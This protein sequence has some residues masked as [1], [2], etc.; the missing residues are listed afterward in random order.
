MKFPIIIKE[1]SDIKGEAREQHGNKFNGLKKKGGGRNNNRK[2]QSAADEFFR[3]VGFSI[4]RDR[5]ELYLKTVERLGIN[6]SRQ[7][8]NRSNMKKC[9]IQEKVAKPEV[10]TL[11][12]IILPTRIEYGSISWAS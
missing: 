7:Y 4:G 9:L 11:Q 12:K 8:K 1:Q 2:P 6:I 5:P 3:G 10:P